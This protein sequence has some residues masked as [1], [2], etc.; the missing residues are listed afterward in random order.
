MF[1]DC[2]V[3]D[4]TRPD[5]KPRQMGYYEELEQLVSSGKYDTR[6]DFTVVLQPQMR[7]MLPPIDVS[8]SIIPPFSTL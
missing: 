2:V 7:D 4:T 6:D 8:V 1:C 3:N 5:L